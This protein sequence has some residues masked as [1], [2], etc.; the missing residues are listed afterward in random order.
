MGD[1]PIPLNQAG[2]RQARALAALV[3][4]ARIACLYSSPVLR[5]LQTARILDEQWRS[6]IV[7]SPGL[8]EIGVG[9]WKNRYWS[10]LSNDPAKRDWYQ[11]P[12]EARPID[13]ETLGEVQRRAVAAVQDILQ[14]ENDH[15]AMVS[16]ADVI[17]AILAHYLGFELALMRRMVLDHAAVTALHI[18]PKPV[19]LLFN[20]RPDV[21]TVADGL[22]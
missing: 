22:P 20:Y 11:R 18:T 5:A 19:L 10:E 1:Q 2:E 3:S 16:H 13:G 6:G 12:E 15:V 8:S 9:V 7:E 21:R 4:R 17:R 14:A